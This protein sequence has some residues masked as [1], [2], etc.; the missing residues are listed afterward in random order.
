MIEYSL[1]TKDE[2]ERLLNDR[3]RVNAQYKPIIQTL[4]RSPGVF[5]KVK[6]TPAIPALTVSK[7]IREYMRRNN[8]IPLGFAVHVRAIPSSK[9]V[10]MFSS[11]IQTGEQNEHEENK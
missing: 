5:I 10:I 1:I 7:R 4:T 8:L 3:Q 11:E 2:A 9:D 6:S